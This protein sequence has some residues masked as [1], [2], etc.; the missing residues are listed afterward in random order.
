MATEPNMSIVVFNMLPTSVQSRI[1]DLQSLRRSKNFS[2]LSS[3][4]RSSRRQNDVD[5]VVVEQTEG[6]VVELEACPPTPSS[7]AGNPLE[8]G[9]PK[10]PGSGRS[11]TNANSGVK[12]RYAE[13]GTDPLRSSLL[14][15]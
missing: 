13:Q 2:I 1:P 14:N 5:Q 7:D 4:L 12:W 8:I 6:S 15:R 9:R 11:L 10:Y 3:R